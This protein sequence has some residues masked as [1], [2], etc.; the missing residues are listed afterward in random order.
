MIQ[1]WTVLPASNIIHSPELRLPTWCGPSRETTANHLRL[2]VLRYQQSHSPHRAVRSHAFWSCTTTNHVD[3]LIE[4][5]TI[6]SS[7]GKGQKAKRLCP[8]LRRVFIPQFVGKDGVNVKALSVN[9]G[10]EIQRH[11]KGPSNFKITGDALIVEAIKVAIDEWLS[12]KTESNAV[13]SFH[14]KKPNDLAF[15][16][17]EKGE[18]CKKNSN[19]E[20]IGYSRG[21]C[22]DAE[23][24]C[25]VFSRRLMNKK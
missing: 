25:H 12:R 16:F 8:H 19:A 9:H 7:C 13:H 20:Y 22:E 2:L 6:K 5:R 17:G 11:T 14:V 1:I 21:G 4:Y 23:R 18:V 10:A 24:Q 3:V 15:N